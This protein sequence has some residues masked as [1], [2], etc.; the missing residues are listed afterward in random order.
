MRLADREFSGVS[1]YQRSIFFFRRAPRMTL[2][3][4]LYHWCVSPCLPAAR[5]KPKLKSTAYQAR[6]HTTQVCHDAICKKSYI[7]LMCSRH[8]SLFKAI[9]KGGIMLAGPGKSTHSACAITLAAV[10]HDPSSETTSLP[11][12]ARAYCD[13]FT[14]FDCCETCVMTCYEHALRH[15]LLRT[16]EKD[17]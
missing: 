16:A 9:K 2:S 4:G 3:P 14:S 17:S 12:H 1:I 13:R 11:R 7:C 15:D 6:Q 5:A 10:V 8:A